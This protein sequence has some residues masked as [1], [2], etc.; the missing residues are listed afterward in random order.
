MRPVLRLS[1]ALALL[2]AALWGLSPA[3]SGATALAS[4]GSLELKG[5]VETAPGGA[6]G[7]WRIGGTPFT[8]D[9]ATVFRDGVPGVG[10]CVEVRYDSVGGQNLAR[11]IKRDDSCAP[12]GTPTEARGRI[13]Q[14]PSGLSGA[15]M[16]AGVAYTADAGTRFE[17]TFGAFAVGRCVEVAFAQTAATRRATKIETKPDDGCGREDEQHEAYAIVEQL[18]SGTGLVGNWTIGGAVYQVSATTALDNGPFAVGALVEVHYTR[19]A[20]GSRSAQRIEGKAGADDRAEGKARGRITALPGT[21]GQLG[22]WVVGGTSYRVTT[23]TRLETESAPFAVGACVEV[24]YQNASGSERVATSIGREGDDDCVGAPGANED[25]TD[26]G[27]VTVLPASGFLGAWTI[28]GVGYTVVPS[29]T[30]AEE[31]GGLALGS[32]VAVEYR[33]QGAERVAQRIETLVPPGAGEHTV[34]GRLRRSIGTAATTT[35]WYVD[36]TAYRITPATL[37][38]VR[39]APLVEGQPVLVNATLGADGAWEATR[40]RTLATLHTVFLP[41]AQR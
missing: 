12:N 4:D 39:Q 2:A 22:L 41:L 30:L 31:H 5:R 20:D 17:Q 33:V 27:F 7:A 35:L 21:A 36:G 40:L 13:E 29:T 14:F 6:T 19:A 9:N 8:T 24:Q 11:A 28:G 23:A 18:P 38:D 1:I 26:Y 37:V 10:D 25:A 15:W 32:F 34:A 16:I 3:P